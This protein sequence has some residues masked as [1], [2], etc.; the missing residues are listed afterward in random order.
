MKYN[1]EA[2]KEVLN[3]T[4]SIEERGSVD[5]M[6]AEPIRINSVSI[7]LQG[8]EIT[9]EQVKNVIMNFA[10]VNPSLFKGGLADVVVRNDIQGFTGNERKYDS[11][12]KWIKPQGNTIYIANADFKVKDGKIFNPFKEMKGALEAIANGKELTFNQE[13]SLE[14]LWHEIRHAGAVGWG[15]RNNKD[16]TTSLPMEVINQFCARMSYRSFVHSLGGKATHSNSVIL[17]GYG[18]QKTLN[19]F[20]S[21]LSQIGVSRVKAYKH[22][23]DMIMRVPYENIQGELINFIT[24]N[25]K[26]DLKDVENIVSAIRFDSTKFKTCL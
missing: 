19:N 18:Y 26:Y 23:K 17:N 22:F 6:A 24:S 5:Y 16:K 9:D 10:E 20:Y 11:N 14:A 25:G 8:E 15:N 2:V 3:P 12:G 7:D 21:L 1:K 13:Y 4:T